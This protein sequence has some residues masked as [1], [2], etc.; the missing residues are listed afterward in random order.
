METSGEGR[1]SDDELF[2]LATTMVVAGTDTTSTALSRILHLLS[3]QPNIQA[4]LRDEIIRAQATD[5]Y[6]TDFQQDGLSYDA[7]QELPFL[8]AVCRETLRLFAPLPFRN[9]RCVLGF[10]S[11]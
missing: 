9:R 7:L 3:L 11:A 10:P 5:S 4:K 2:A 1:V 8:D 6:D